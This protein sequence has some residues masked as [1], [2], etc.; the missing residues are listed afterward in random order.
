MKKPGTVYAKPGG[1][2][3]GE[4]AAP[5]EGVTLLGKEGTDWFHVKWPAGEGWVYSLPG[6]ED[7]IACP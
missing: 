3:I 5:T 1:D 7:A 2:A 4:L 6:Y